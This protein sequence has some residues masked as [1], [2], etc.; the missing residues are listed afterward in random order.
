MTCPS[1]AMNIPVGTPSLSGTCYARRTVNVRV[2]CAAT[3]GHT[4]KNVQTQ[5]RHANGLVCAHRL[6]P[7]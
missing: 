3:Y 7:F 6:L 2:S 4:L 1:S 5:N